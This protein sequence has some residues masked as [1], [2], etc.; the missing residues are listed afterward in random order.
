MENNI[1]FIPKTYQF[2]TEL[3]VEVT[4][5]KIIVQDDAG[6]SSVDS[7]N[8][9][10]LTYQEYWETRI[11]PAGLGMRFH[12]ISIAII[13]IL[14]TVVG[15]WTEITLSVTLFLIIMNVAI[16]LFAMVDM[17]LELRIIDNIV[18]KYFSDHV[19]LVSIG[20]SN[21]NNVEFYAQLTEKD[22]ILSLENQVNELKLLS[23]QANKSES[24]SNQTNL[25]ELKKLGELYKLGILTEQEFNDKKQELLNKH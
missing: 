1:A 21:G 16:F 19:Y 23:Q 13:I 22:K 17:F 5:E 24:P 2:E 20:N 8:L 10:N 9:N 15:A 3:T 6:S 11:S 7:Y 18:M 25:D 4:K 12:G 14:E